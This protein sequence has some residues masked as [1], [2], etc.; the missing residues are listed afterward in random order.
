MRA[1]GALTQ[2]CGENRNK[3]PPILLESWKELSGYPGIESR[4]LSCGSHNTV[5]LP[6]LLPLLLNRSSSDNL[7]IFVLLLLCLFLEDL[8]FLEENR[9][10][11]LVKSKNAK[12]E[13]NV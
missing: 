8:T 7:K 1:S 12:K 10:V 13:V 3:T 4:E 9:E 2:A 5:R 11:G 6:T